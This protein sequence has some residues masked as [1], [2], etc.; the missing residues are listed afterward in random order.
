MSHT[1]LY[2]AG[3]VFNYL[4]YLIKSGFVDGILSADPDLWGSILLGP[5]VTLFYLLFT[6]IMS[7]L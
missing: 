4:I 1:C 2:L 6:Q 3:W 7:S 5:L